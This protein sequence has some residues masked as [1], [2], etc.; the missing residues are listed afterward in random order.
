MKKTTY[1]SEWNEELKRNL[2][3][4][5]RKITDPNYSLFD[6]SQKLY[7]YMKRFSLIFSLCGIP[8]F[9]L[10]L[11]I[12]IK[13]SILGIIPLTFGGLGVMVVFYSPYLLLEY[14]KFKPI[15]E[16]KKTKQ[17]NALVELAKKYSSSN[18]FIDQE[19]ARL[20][21]YLLVDFKSIEIAHILKD[22]LSQRKPPRLTDILRTFSLL[23]I[24]LGYKDHEDFIKDLIDGKQVVEEKQVSI[25]DVDYETVV[26]ITK[27]YFLDEIPY[28]AK[29]MV[30]GLKLDFK[31]D[32]IVV[33]PFCSAWSKKELLATW[34]NDKQVCPVCRRKLLLDDCPTVQIRFDK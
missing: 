32:T 28:D 17:I 10:G 20:A 16:M 31:N 25:D 14:L 24:K 6:E 18:G 12:I 3:K 23:A 30:S 19:R 2:K 15:M 7:N 8:L 29:C 34:L 26:P 27:V 21:T 4:R 11:V 33:C 22:R 1:S 5:F 13:V 9:V